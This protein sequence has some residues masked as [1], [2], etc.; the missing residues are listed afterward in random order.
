MVLGEKS[1]TK[2]DRTWLPRVYEK[3]IVLLVTCGEEGGTPSNQNQD[4]VVVVVPQCLL[5]ERRRLPATVLVRS[6]VTAG[7]QKCGSAAEQ[8]RLPPSCLQVW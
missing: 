6:L 3:S 7:V 4:F 1:R 8:C 5:H 2:F